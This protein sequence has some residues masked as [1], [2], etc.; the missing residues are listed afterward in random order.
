MRNRGFLIVGILLVVWGILSLL[1]NLLKIDTWAFCWPVVLILIGVW[2]L[3]RPRFRLQGAVVNVLP[4]N[5]TRRSGAWTVVDE[6]DFTLIGDT[7]LDMTQAEI[8]PGETVLRVYGFV[9]AVDLRLPK[10]VGISVTSWA[11]VT[12]ARLMGQK[13]DT[14]LSP[15]EY[16]SPGYE[17]AER[18]VRLET[19][20]FVVDLDVN[21]D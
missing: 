12:D 2:L 10:E 14:F 15:V 9:G 16:A 21:Q 4:L 18:R 13:S 7:R 3:L 8:H 17:S 6:E 1:G 19:Y 20:F 11:F 5:N